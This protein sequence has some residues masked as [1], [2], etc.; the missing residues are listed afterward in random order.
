VDRLDTERDLKMWNVFVIDNGECERV[1]SQPYDI[2]QIAQL[3]NELAELDEP[4]GSVLIT[5][6]RCSPRVPFASAR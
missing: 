6:V 4:L 5:E 1:N 2:E 3:L